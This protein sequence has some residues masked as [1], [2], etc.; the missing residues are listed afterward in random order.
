MSRLPQFSGLDVVSMFGKICYRATR[1]RGSHMRLQ[2]QEAP[3][4][5]PLTV[6]NHRTIAKGLLRKLIRD[7]NI[8]IEEFL[9]LQ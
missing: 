9:R 6:P 7:A 4:R 5:K 2:H 3:R 8:T 1:Q